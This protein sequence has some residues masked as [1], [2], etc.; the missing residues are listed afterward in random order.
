MWL[1]KSK[2]EGNVFNIYYK[3]DSEKCGMCLYSAPFTLVPLNQI[4]CN[5]QLINKWN[6]SMCNIY[7]DCLENMV[8]KQ[9]H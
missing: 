6:P 2:V 8:K 7:L 1:Q 9:H 4:Q 3:Y 5:L